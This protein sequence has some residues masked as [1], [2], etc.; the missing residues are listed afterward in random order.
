MLF[1]CPTKKRLSL[2]PLWHFGRLP[3]PGFPLQPLRATGDGGW[4]SVPVFTDMVILCFCSC[5]VLQKWS[6]WSQALIL[7]LRHRTGNCIGI[8][9]RSVNVTH[10]SESWRIYQST[11]GKMSTIDRFWASD[12]KRPITHGLVWAISSQQLIF[13]RTW[14]GCFQDLF[15]PEVCYEASLLLD[16]KD[17]CRKSCK[18]SCSR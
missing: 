15:S 16:R 18:K 13:V 11:G 9:Q 2:S 6:S 8:Y 14:P 1:K 17:S 4:C 12:E 3:E 7:F 5:C 10:V